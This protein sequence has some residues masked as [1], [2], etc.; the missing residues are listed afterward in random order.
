MDGYSCLTKLF[1][2]QKNLSCAFAQTLLTDREVPPS[3]SNLRTCEFGKIEKRK[4]LC[5]RIFAY[6]RVGWK[7]IG[8]ILWRS[9]FGQKNR[10]G[11]VV[12]FCLLLM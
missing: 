10:K 9:I 5:A 12:V 4:T 8:K 11:P 7:D 6:L 2:L 3:P 1:P